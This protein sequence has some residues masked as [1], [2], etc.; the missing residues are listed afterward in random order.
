M[1]YII[2]TIV[3]LL[4]LTYVFFRVKHHFIPKKHLPVYTLVFIVLAL[5]YPLTNFFFEAHFQAL[6]DKLVILGSFSAVFFLYILLSILLLDL[7]LIFNRFLHIIPRPVIKSRRHQTRGLLTIITLSLAVVIGGIVHFNSIRTSGY[8]V[9]IPRRNAQVDQLKIAFIADFHIQQ[10]TNLHYV[11]R[12]KEKINALKPDLVLFGGDIV[13]G[14][15]NEDKLAQFEQLISQIESRYGNYGVIG[16]HEI[17]GG[18]ETEQF[19]NNAGIQLLK[20]TVEVVNS[21]V[22]LIGRLDEHIKDRKSLKELLKQSRD[23]L[24]IIM[25]DH[26]PTKIPE[27]S[28]TSV[29]MQLSGH[30]HN[31]QLFPFNLITKSIYPLSWGYE[32]LDNTHF[33]VTSGIRLW[34][35]PVRTTG[36]SEIMVID[37]TFR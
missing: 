7:L 27:V 17:Y 21:S 37:I 32:N 25:V 12:V 31:G 13:E 15:G 14:D 10:K 30:T 23:S 36:L 8:H 20:D 22:N 19:F 28:K 24:P 18:K 1:F 3:Y 2:V 29:D 26:R 34:G 33:F 11:E 9:E 4:P 6:S 16:N 35:P 5:S